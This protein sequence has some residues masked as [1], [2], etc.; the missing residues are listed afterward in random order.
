MGHL[1]LGT[2][3]DWVP[4]PGVA[5]LWSAATTSREK[6]RQAPTSAV[7]PSYIQSR[8]LRAF[9]EQRRRGL[10]MSRLL[11][12]AFDI[13]GECDIRAM[14]Y[15][16]NA[17]L[18]RHD[19]YRS[20]FEFAG[21]TAERIV[22][23][24]IADPADIELV[25]IQQGEM[26][27]TQWQEYLLGTPSPLDW[28]CFRF[29]I[30]QRDDHFTVCISVDHLHVDPMFI[31]SVFW[32]IRAMYNALMDGEGPIALPPAGSYADY[33]LRERAY[34][35][36]LTLQSPEIRQW[37][38]FFQS[39]GGSLPSFPLPLGDTSLLTNGD[40]LS[41]RLMDADQTARFEAA[42]TAAG[43]RFSGG[44]FAC[45]AQTEY[46]LTGSTTYHAVTPVG[47]R[48]ISTEF[49]TTGWFIGHAP[50]V[51][52]VG[53]SFGETARDAQS[54]FDASTHLANVP[55]ERVL[56]LAPWLSKPPPR[57][58]FP[59]LSFLD[60][61]VPPLSAVISTQLGQ[62]NTRAFSDGRIAARVCMWVN[63]FHEE[64][65]VTAS[66]PSNPVAYE[67]IAQ[68]LHTMK[69]VYLRVAEGRELNRQVAA[70]LTG[71]ASC[72]DVYLA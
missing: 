21:P 31:G 8:H 67:S 36:S 64:T 47:T 42:C 28:D 59:M 14:T 55:F 17:H 25:A 7:P 40:L 60:G 51:V 1:G 20:W 32:E 23:H 19:T 9:H 29:A 6:A 49:L 52:P 34:T 15:V 54:A 50:F 41:M 12:I 43:A 16:F 30:I 39:N 72:E 46:E 71:S 10:D 66:F 24:T 68:Y 11:V 38:E 65:T 70:P 2:V 22:R 58:G 57:G 26:S 4:A 3:S 53:L 44:V 37:I 69:S 48:S 63:K 35:S 61:G 13:P 45:A 18:R 27:P 56:E 5:W 62:M 33:C